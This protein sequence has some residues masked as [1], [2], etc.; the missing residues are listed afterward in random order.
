MYSVT[1]GFL[2]FWSYR[3]DCPSLTAKS[4]TFRFKA[5]T[6]FLQKLTVYHWHE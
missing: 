3:A 6:S 4:T 2:F 1:S 5:Q